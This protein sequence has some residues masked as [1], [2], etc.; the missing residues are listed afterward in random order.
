MRR[1]DTRFDRRI[2]TTALNDFNLL[3]RGTDGCGSK[4]SLVD[5][6]GAFY[7]RR[8]LQDDAVAEQ[9]DPTRVSIRGARNGPATLVGK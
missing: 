4:D 8:L 5:L 9:V 7:P 2:D 6:R 3:P 1:V